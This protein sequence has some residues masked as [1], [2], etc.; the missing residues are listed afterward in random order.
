ADAV[1]LFAWNEGAGVLEPLYA[2]DAPSGAPLRPGEGVAGQAFVQRRPVLVADYPRQPER[3]AWA[4]ERGTCVAAA[5]PLIVGTR[6]IG[7]L[8][9]RRHRPEPYTLEQAEVLTLLA[10]FVAPALE[11]ARLHA[12]SDHQR[13]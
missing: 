10:A 2:F 6:A 3:L 9:V 12:E 1:G 5:V 4:V 13:R 7:V 11:A 8:A